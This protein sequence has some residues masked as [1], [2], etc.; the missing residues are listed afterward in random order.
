MHNPYRKLFVALNKKRIQYLIVGG[1]A[2]NL[3]GYNR[4][5][6][7][8]DIL[9][10]LDKQNLE[11]LALV[12]SRLGYVQRLPVNLIELGNKKRVKQWIKEKNMTAYTFISDTMP[13]LSLDIL[14]G[15]S[16]DFQ[17]YYKRSMVLKIWGLNVPVVS[18]D[19]LVKMKKQ[20]GREQDLLDL[21]ML[22]E[23][24]GL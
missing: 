13:Q 7:D 14:A 10:A 4:H 19:D 6:G 12:M 23:L 15:Y 22:L 24:K 11:K 18:F 21:K 8:I 17:K 20:A 3:Y 5:T 2:V 9:M 1:V 16:L